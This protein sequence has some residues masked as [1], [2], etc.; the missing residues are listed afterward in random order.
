MEF[1]CLEIKNLKK[2]YATAFKLLI[3]GTAISVVAGP[4]DFLWHETFGVDGLLSP[5]HLALITDMLINSV[6]VVVGLARI[7]VHI[8]VLS[9]KQRLIKLAMIPA[10]AALWFTTTWY[11]YMF[12]L[13]FSNGENFQ[14]NLNSSI[15]TIIAITALPLLSSI[16]FLTA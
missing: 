2:S 13:P 15:A 8:P 16:I 7:V 9:T 12:S 6:A 5:P 14:F 1:C 10:F 11:V 3:I 4:S